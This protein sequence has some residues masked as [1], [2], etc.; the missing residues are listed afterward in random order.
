[1]TYS[2]Q[3]LQRQTITLHNLQITEKQHLPTCLQQF[4]QATVNN[5]TV[6]TKGKTNNSTLLNKKKKS[7][8]LK[9]MKIS[10]LQLV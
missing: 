9:K 6:Q 10:V 5:K 1:M 4:I 2:P 8:N 7:Y 3:C